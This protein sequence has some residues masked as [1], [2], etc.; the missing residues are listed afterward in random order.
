[1]NV[2][3]FYNPAEDRVL[4]NARSRSYGAP[5]AWAASSPGDHIKIAAD[6][7]AAGRKVTESARA[8]S[9]YSS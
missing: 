7:H 5:A 6:V 1:M 8:H 2:L 4:L 3:K 9:Y